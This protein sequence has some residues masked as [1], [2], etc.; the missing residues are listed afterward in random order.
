ERRH[1]IRALE[2]HDWA[3]AQTADSLGIHRNTLRMKMKEY[4][5]EK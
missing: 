3:F 1:I 4:A 2:Y 5:I